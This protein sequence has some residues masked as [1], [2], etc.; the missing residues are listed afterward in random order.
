MKNLFICVVILSPCAQ[1]FLLL[2]ISIH[3]W[4]F[5]LSYDY[6]Y[7]Q[8]ELDIWEYPDFPVFCL[9]SNMAFLLLLFHFR[10]LLTV[11]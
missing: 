4:W 11:E 9:F 8:Y 1:L 3:F 6:N 7:F 5:L 10:S 2:I